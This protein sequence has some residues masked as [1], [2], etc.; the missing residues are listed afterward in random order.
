MLINE[1]VSWSR[2]P[3]R[4]YGGGVAW[5]RLAL[6]PPSLAWARSVVPTA[7]FS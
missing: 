4:P 7:T 3:R 5:D 1:E 6:V 2:L